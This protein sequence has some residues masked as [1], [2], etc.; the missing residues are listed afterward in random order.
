MFL[1]CNVGIN[2]ILYILQNEN[3]IYENTHDQ[4]PGQEMGLPWYAVAF[5]FDNG[6]VVTD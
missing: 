5:L 1:V 3:P 6:F 4:P 2:Q